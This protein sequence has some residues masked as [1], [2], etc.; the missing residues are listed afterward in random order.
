MRPSTR[1]AIQQAVSAIPGVSR[2]TNYAEAPRVGLATSVVPLVAPKVA[3]FDPAGPFTLEAW[4]LPFSANQSALIMGKNVSGNPFNHFALLVSRGQFLVVVSDG[5]PGSAR[6]AGSP[7]NSVAATWTHVAGVFDGSSLRLYVDGVLR[8][9]TTGAPTPVAAVDTPFSIGQGVAPDGGALSSNFEGVIS[10]ARFWN[11]ARSTDQINAG[12]K[13]GKP[14]DTSGLVGSW[15]LDEGTGISAADHSGR[16]HHLRPNSTLIEWAPMDGTN[17][18][19][20][21]AA[22]HLATV[23]T[24]VAFQK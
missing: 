8:S 19:R 5:S 18:E 16:G 24:D 3:A 23:S 10:Q 21:R 20:V 11:V 1:S 15:L 17:L 6:A 13:E 9:Q 4:V 2:L 12:M 22:I 14:T 7:P